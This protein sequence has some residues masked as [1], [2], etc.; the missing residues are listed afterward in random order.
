MK[1]NPETY[2]Q[3][4]SLLLK[5]PTTSKDIPTVIDKLQEKKVRFLKIKNCNFI[6]KN[7]SNCTIHKQNCSTKPSQFNE[8]FHIAISLEKI[9]QIVPF[10]S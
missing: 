9:R 6:C 2:V 10:I 7:S 5:P 8:F 3:F 1:H 4:A